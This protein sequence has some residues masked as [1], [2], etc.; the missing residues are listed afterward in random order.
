MVAAA[1]AGAL[2]STVFTYL[3]RSESTASVSDEQLAGRVGLVVLPVAAD[4]RGRVAISVA[5]QQLYLTARALPDA[6][7][8]LEN[9]TGVDLFKALRP[10][11]N[12]LSVD[13]EEP[14]E[15]D[16]VPDGDGSVAQVGPAQ[17]PH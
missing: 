12:G 3:R 8:E 10:D 16:A 9:A 2:N 4:R 13:A 11:S 1:A 15:E 6:T 17:E 5:G 7:A 14:W